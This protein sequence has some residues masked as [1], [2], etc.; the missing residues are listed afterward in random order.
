[1]KAAKWIGLNDLT[2]PLTFSWT[3]RSAVTF[4]YWGV[5][6]PIKHLGDVKDCVF[7]DGETSAWKLSECDNTLSSVCKRPSEIV[8]AP[9][10]PNGCEQVG[11]RAGLEMLNFASELFRTGSSVGRLL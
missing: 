9:E 11:L 8:A 6:E 1:M 4:T 7:M 5:N 3:D 2:Q 10:V